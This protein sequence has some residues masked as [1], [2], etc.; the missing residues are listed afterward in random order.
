MTPERELL[1]KN[2]DDAWSI[3][4][5][6]QGAATLAMQKYRESVEQLLDHDWIAAGNQRLLDEIDVYRRVAE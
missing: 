6:L 2:V 5:S 3:V 4:V 1:L